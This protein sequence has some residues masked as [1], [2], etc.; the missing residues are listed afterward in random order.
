[1][2]AL[3]ALLG[4]DINIKEQV[5]IKRLDTNFTVK[6]LDDETF[7]EIQEEATNYVGSGAKQRKVVDESKLNTSIV[8]KAVVDENGESLFKNTKL[9]EKYG[10]K[11]A[12]ECVR[13]ALL[14]GEVATLVKAVLDIS[15]FDNDVEDIK[16]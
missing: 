1:M 7:N 11:T 16:N 13:K 10:A 5:Y 4:A 14:V 9:L 6:A 12:E 15:G 3:Q 8:A 2:D